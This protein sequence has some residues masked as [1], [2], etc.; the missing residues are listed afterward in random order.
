MKSVKYENESAH[1]IIKCKHGVALY[2]MKNNHTDRVPMLL[3]P[4]INDGYAK[5]TVTTRFTNPLGQKRTKLDEK[6]N[7]KYMRKT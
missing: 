1:K 5:K 3:A 7:K 6:K 2:F 4:S